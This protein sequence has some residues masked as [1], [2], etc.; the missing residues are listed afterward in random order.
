MGSS[1]AAARVLSAKERF[2]EAAASLSGLAAVETVIESKLASDAPLL[3][4]IPQYLFSV[5]GKRVRPLLA[6]L[7]SR[8]L[9]AAQPPRPQQRRVRRGA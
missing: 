8:A 4:E 2:R 6:L 1:S 7:V 9:G 3:R 5:G